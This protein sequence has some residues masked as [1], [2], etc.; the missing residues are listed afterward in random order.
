M[1]KRSFVFGFATTLLCTTPLFINAISPVEADVLIAPDG[2]AQAQV[3]GVP[4]QATMVSLEG[5]QLRVKLSGFNASPRA[6]EARIRVA[7]LAD[8]PMGM[9][10]RIMLPPQELTHREVVIPVAAGERLD[11]II[12]LDHK[13]LENASIPALKPGK[14]PALQGR[15][16]RVR[17][18]DGRG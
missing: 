1:N 6:V 7:V 5:T 3:G 4:F 9:R 15:M 8:R 11:R 2:T 14:A 13:S 17:L 18:S 16:L 12:L 10:S